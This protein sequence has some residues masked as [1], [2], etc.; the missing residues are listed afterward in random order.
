MAEAGEPHHHPRA[1]EE[2]EAGA[3]RRGL[4]NLVLPH[5]AEWTPE[6]AGAATGTRV[7]MRTIL[8]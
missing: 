3:E 8:T 6:R 4:W 2:L 1:L 7:W 5:V